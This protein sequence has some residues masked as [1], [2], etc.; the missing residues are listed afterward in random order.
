MYH[1]LPWDDKAI[2]Q[3]LVEEALSLGATVS[4]HD[5]GEW[6]VARSTDKGAIIDAV[7]NTDTDTIRVR[8]GEQRADFHLVYGNR[9]GTTI[10][11]YSANKLADR[12]MARL[13]PTIRNCGG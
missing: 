8:L 3:A 5:G 12:L 9:D 10:S 1:Q 11:A 13:V 6:A 4:V 7:G 2:A